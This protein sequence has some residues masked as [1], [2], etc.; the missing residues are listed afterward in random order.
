MILHLVL[1]Y[2]WFDEMLAGRKDVEYRYL[3]NKWERDI[4]AKREQIT[5]ARF[6]RAYD[7]NPATILRRVTK[8]DIGP[9]PYPGWSEDYYRIHLEPIHSRATERGEG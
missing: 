3:S 4:W 6:Q 7:K 1:T 8:I 2:H 5:H 9:C